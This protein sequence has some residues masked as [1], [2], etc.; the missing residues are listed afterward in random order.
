MKTSIAVIILGLTAVAAPAQDDM[1]QAIRWER[2]K[3]AAAAHEAHRVAS[4]TR[5]VA[6]PA[7][8]SPPSSSAT[9]SAP[10]VTDPGP[11]PDSMRWDRTNDKPAN[12]KTKNTNVASAKSH[13]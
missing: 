3:A 13:K 10:V 2:A 4:H 8:P 9:P 1:Q 6:P 5:K 12:E 7:K 11:L